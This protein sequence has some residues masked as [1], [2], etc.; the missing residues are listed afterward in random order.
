[1]SPKCYVSNKVHGITFLNITLT[2]YVLI[3]FSR[4]GLG[5]VCVYD[6]CF[7]VYCLGNC[8]HAYHVELNFKAREIMCRRICVALS[9]G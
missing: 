4:A 5:L 7:C 9:Y 2:V 1:M 3:S 6:A 8:E